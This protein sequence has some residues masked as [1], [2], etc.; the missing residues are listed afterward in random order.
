[1]LDDARKHF[2]PNP[3]WSST[4]ARLFKRFREL[5]VELAA[6]FR[7]IVGKPIFPEL[8]EEIAARLASSL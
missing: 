7:E 5:D 2:T 4:V 6:L 8:P 1:M 3:V